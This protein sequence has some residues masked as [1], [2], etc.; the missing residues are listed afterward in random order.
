MRILRALAL[1]NSAL[2]AICRAFADRCLLKESEFVAAGIRRQLRL[3]RLPDKAFRTLE[4]ALVAGEDRR[5]REHGGV[6]ARGIVRA[7]FSMALEKRIQGASTIEQQLVRTLRRRYEVTIRRKVSEICIACFVSARFTKDDILYAYLVVAYFGWRSNGIRAA[8]Q[9]Y[10]YSI[11][12]LSD[13]QAAHI[14]A[15][16]RYP[17]PSSPSEELMARISQRQAYI[18]RLAR[19]AKQ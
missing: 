6:D 12:S 1:T 3:R 19:H 2:A 16:L 18:E 4:R 10:K 13:D 11:E 8:L 14:A 7:L 5:F 15:L 17:C 9:R